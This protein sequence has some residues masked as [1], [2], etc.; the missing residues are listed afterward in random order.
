MQNTSVCEVS[1][2]L[3]VLRSEK[4]HLKI[5]K[6]LPYSKWPTSCDDEN[7]ITWK[8]PIYSCLRTTKTRTK[9]SGS[10]TIPGV[11]SNISF[12]TVKMFYSIYFWVERRSFLRHVQ[13]FV[14]FS[15]YKSKTPYFLLQS[16]VKQLE[17]IGNLVWIPIIVVFPW[18]KCF[19]CKFLL[20]NKLLIEFF[21]LL[22]TILSP[23]ESWF[24]R[25]PAST[26]HILS[27]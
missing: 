22:E 11:Q 21:S 12:G 10:I 26:N 23:L 1:R 16:D 25:A 3:N 6:I 17:L 9:S 24:S 14:I 27:S 7:N 5:D 19:S 15:K 2:R 13:T 20:E 4:K 8:T 18:K